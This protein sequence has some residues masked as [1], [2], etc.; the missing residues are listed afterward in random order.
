[1]VQWLATDYLPTLSAQVNDALVRLAC[2]VAATWQPTE[3][4]ATPLAV[5]A[6]QAPRQGQSYHVQL[7]SDEGAAMQ[8]LQAS[9]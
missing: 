8:W 2:L 5:L 9:C 1:M 3:A 7:F 4:P 6:Q